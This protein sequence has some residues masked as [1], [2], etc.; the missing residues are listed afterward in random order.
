MKLGTT[1]KPR[2]DGTVTSR[3]G[4]DVYVFK[5]EA[6]GE[7]Y[8]D[9]ENLAHVAVLLNSGNF[10]PA[11]PDEYEV[12]LSLS[13]NTDVEG[14]D[15]DDDEDSNDDAAPVEA[16]TP[17]SNFRRRGRGKKAAAE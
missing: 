3:F 5:P 9:I 17:P 14:P 4:T 6:D 2:K 11:N 1:I 16:G 13:E 12:A 8:C 10:F 15:D 7:L